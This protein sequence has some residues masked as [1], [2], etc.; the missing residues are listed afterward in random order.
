MPESQMSNQCPF[1]VA[2]HVFLGRC[3][4]RVVSSSGATTVRSVPVLLISV[5]QALL[6]SNTY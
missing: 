6:L 5:P 2:G 3:L 1:M 4:H